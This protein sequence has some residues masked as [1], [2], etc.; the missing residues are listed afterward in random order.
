MLLAPWSAA[1]AEP[2]P[3]TYHWSSSPHEVLADAP[4][5]G[6]IALADDDLHTALGNSDIVATNIQT[7]STATPA[8]PDVF[9][10][11]PF[12][13]FLYLQD[14]LSGIGQTL[15]FTG[16][17]NGQLTAGN[18][19]LVA[20]LTGLTSQTVVLGGNEY[21]VSL[22]SYTPPGQPGSVNLGSIGFHV[23]VVVN[24]PEPGSLALTGLGGCL[25]GARGR[26]LRRRGAMTSW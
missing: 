7:F 12:Q 2:I 14:T 13:L 10:N 6:H 3:W 4:G 23:M 20:T 5:T 8:N 22:P 1:R 17:I 21:T 19:N 11:K 9:T 24:V 18:S 15:E 16:V 25:L 26:R